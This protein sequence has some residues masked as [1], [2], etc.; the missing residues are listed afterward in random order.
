VFL[1]VT[2]VANAFDTGHH[3]DLT[4]EA[5]VDLGFSDIAIQVSQVENW[6]VDYYSN[7]EGGVADSIKTDC[8]KLH[9]DNL[10]N[11]ASVKNYWDRLATN[12]KAA[13]SEAARNNNPRQVLALLG[14]SLHTVQDFY[15][16]SNWAEIQA[17][18]AGFD[19]ATLT[20]FDAGRRTGVKTGKAGST[21]PA[22]HGGYEK[23]D[24]M[25]HDWYGKPNWDRAYV[26]AY[27]ASR[28]WANQARLWVNEVNPAV[29]EQAK[30]IALTSKQL[31]KLSSDL[32]AAYRISEWVKSGSHDGHWKGKGSGDSGSFVAFSAGWI[33]G[34]TDSDFVEDFKNR[35]WHQLLSGGLRGSLDLGVNQPPPSSAPQ[36]TI[37][38]ISK[39]AVFLKTV[40]VKDL[41]NIDPAPYDDADF[42][43]KIGINN[44]TF[45]ESCQN[46]RD[47]LS[48]PWITMKFVDAAIPVVA[49]HYELWDEDTTSGDDHLD[50]E[51]RNGLPNLDFLYNMNTHRVGTIG[52]DGVYDSTSRL[53]VTRG[54]PGDHAEV[55]M[56]ITTRTLG[57]APRNSGDVALDSVEPPIESPTDMPPSGPPNSHRQCLNQ[58]QIRFA[59]CPAVLSARQCAQLRNRCIAS[60]P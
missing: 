42:Y 13:F 7:R 2:A 29:W 46:G 34:T 8:D 26:H 30:R 10:F 56:Y 44:Q 24:G 15:S 27:A 48:P 53:L 47:N 17:P 4:R 33:A 5:L 20:Y 1:S 22:A 14:M 21:G 36:M 40:S 16:H 50:I 59:R 52:I 45:I 60:C 41:D 38:P 32:N 11:E 55:K 9:A 39:R 12:A 18:P 37:F 31:G 19:Y 43:A 3:S 58:C 35:H 28:Q 25:N 6:L 57:P 54:T 51:R 49:I 23:D